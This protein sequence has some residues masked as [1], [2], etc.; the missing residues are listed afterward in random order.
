MIRIAIRLA[1]WP[2][3][4]AIALI[5]CSATNPAPGPLPPFD[6]GD[7]SECSAACERRKI[8]GCLE[9]KFES[10]CVPVCEKAARAGLFRPRCVLDATTRGELA[11]CR[12]RC[13]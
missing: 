1:R 2:Y 6:P 11:D 3:A 12:V 5:A 9:A 8:L 10:A 13:Q 7:A 4:C